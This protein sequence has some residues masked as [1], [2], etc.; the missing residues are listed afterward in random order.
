MHALI[1]SLENRELHFRH[2]L[3]DFLFERR[4]DS[5]LSSS[6]QSTAKELYLVTDT[7]LKKLGHLTRS[8]PHHKDWAPLTLYMQSQARR[9]WG[10]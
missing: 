2:F 7:N 9:I 5:L 3:Q 4:R 8:N 10:A 6:A 1:A